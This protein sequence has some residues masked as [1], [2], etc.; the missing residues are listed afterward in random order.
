MNR[1]LLKTCTYAVMHFVVAVAVA[2]ALTRDI[3]LA[4]AV[5]LIEPMVQTLA[6]AVHERL[7][8]RTSPR[9][10]AG[11]CAHTALAAFLNRQPVGD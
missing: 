2:F 6:F 4:L 7:W 3:H 5:G 1:V 8:S 10:P 11:A 9:K